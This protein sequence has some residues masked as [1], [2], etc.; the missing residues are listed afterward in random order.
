LSSSEWRF[1]F[2]TMVFRF[3]FIVG[4]EALPRPLC[5]PQRNLC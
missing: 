5:A 3:V 4:V 2:S 1:H